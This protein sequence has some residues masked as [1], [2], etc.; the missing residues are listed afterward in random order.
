MSEVIAI[1]DEVRLYGELLGRVISI[2]LCVGLFVLDV[3]GITVVAQRHQFQPVKWDGDVIGKTGIG[4]CA[5]NSS[6]EIA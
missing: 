3:D 4:V 6:E 2:E 1:G 5:K